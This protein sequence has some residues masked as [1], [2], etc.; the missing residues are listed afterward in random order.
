MIVIIQGKKVKKVLDR[1]FEPKYGSDRAA[2]FAL[3]G[4]FS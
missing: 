1:V 4:I 2:I 3:Q